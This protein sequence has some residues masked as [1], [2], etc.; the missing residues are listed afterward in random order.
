[1][2]QTRIK[3]TRVLLK[4]GHADPDLKAQEIPCGKHGIDLS[5]LS[6]VLNMESILP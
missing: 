6:H 2:K 5:K 1:M 3:L 4:T